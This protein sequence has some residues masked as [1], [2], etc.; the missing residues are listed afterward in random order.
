MKIERLHLNKITF[1]SLEKGDVFG[2]GEAVHMKI[3]NNKAVNLRSGQLINCGEL[4]PVIIYPDAKLV[5]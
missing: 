2:I 5:V 3:V 1:G 4:M